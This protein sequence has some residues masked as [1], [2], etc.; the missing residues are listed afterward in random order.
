MEILGHSQISTTMNVYTHVTTDSAR[1]A[2]ERMA[3]LFG[4]EAGAS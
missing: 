4:Q 2:T 1:E 3:D